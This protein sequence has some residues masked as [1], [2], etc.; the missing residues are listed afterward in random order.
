M[1][2]GEYPCLVNLP[3]ERNGRVASA[4]G[5]KLSSSPHPGTESGHRSWE[6]PISKV[7]MDGSFCLSLVY[8]VYNEMETHTATQA[9]SLE[10][11]LD[12][13]IS[14]QRVKRSTQNW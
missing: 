11:S 2:T 8:N 13:L 3:Q 5:T 1:R 12:F 10:I 4:A 14:L 6:T 7:N 9:R